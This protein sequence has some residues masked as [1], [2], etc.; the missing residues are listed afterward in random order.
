MIHVQP[1]ARL[2][3]ALVATQFPQWSALSV[4]ALA[5][6]GTDHAL[7]RLGDTMLVRLPMSQSA[8]GQIEK[9][10]YWL[11][12]LAPHVTSPLISIPA[13]LAVGE[14]E[15]SFPWRWGIYGWIE[16]E[17][18]CSTRIA[19]AKQ[20]AE[21][22]AQFVVAMRS[23]P[24]DGTPIP[25]DSM[26]RG[27]P[28]WLRDTQTRNSIRALSNEIDMPKS[29]HIWEQAL[30]AAPWTRSPCW[31]HGDLLPGNLLLR[32]GRLCAVIDFGGARVG[33]PA[34]DVMAAWI[35]FDRK[36]RPSFRDSVDVDDATWQRA[37]GWALSWSVIALA[38]YRDS[39][40]P[41][42]AIARRTIRA[43]LS[44]PGD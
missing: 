6:V 5:S 16:G 32:N 24:Y 2:V 3:E 44:E 1:D 37:R 10:H 39:L 38:F 31:V 9:E 23:A 33:D 11:P 18:L 40:S 4:T 20:L 19:D 29:E 14:A 17:S 36:V 22:L 25:P 27:E 30:S 21:D 41:L 26:M 15:T 8:A 34:V 13:P 42:S 7:F 35:I 28:L 12:I 43:V